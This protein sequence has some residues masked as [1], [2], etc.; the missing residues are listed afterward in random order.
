MHSLLDTLQAMKQQDELVSSLHSQVLEK[1]KASNI[2]GALASF[3]KVN[4]LL[5]RRYARAF[6]YRKRGFT[7]TG[8]KN[9]F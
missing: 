5:L 3:Y 2:Q 6:S 1:V 8:R 7:A 9:N 4:M